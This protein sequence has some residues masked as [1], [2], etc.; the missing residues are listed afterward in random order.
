MR[1]CVWWRNLKNEEAMARVGH[2]ENRSADVT[3]LTRNVKSASI[4]QWHTETTNS[5]NLPQSDL[6]TKQK[7]TL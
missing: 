3:V 6:F 7:L 2:D 5:Q 4:V 1:R